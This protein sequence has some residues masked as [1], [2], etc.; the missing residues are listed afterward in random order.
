MASYKY[1]VYNSARQGGKRGGSGG[2]SGGGGKRRGEYIDPARFV[3]VAKP[4]QAAD[5]HAEHRFQDFEIDDLLKQN[6][7]ERAGH[8]EPAT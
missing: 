5:Y 7:A 4:T 6:L 2:R 8:E 3:A 1:S